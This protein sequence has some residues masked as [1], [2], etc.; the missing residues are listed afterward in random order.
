MSHALVL[1]GGGPVGVA[2]EIGVL[3]GLSEAGFDLSAADRVIGTSAGAIVG[4]Q[5]AT[6][7][8]ASDLYADHLDLVHR[9]TVEAEAG[10]VPTADLGALM[11]L[12]M[13]RPPGQM[14]SPALLS[15]MG[16]FALETG[17][18]GEEDFV[19][20]VSR[21][22]LTG[23]PWPSR[24]ACTAIEAATGTFKLWNAASGADL[25]RAVASSCAVP[26]LY[27]PITIDGRRYMDGGMRSATNAD[28]AAGADAVLVLAVTVRPAEFYMAAGARQE[29]ATLREQGSR[30]E[31]ILPDE[32]AL[33]AFGPN[34]MDWSRH[35]AVSAA[36]LAQ[37]RREAERLAFWPLS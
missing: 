37:G 25:D 23:Q 13:R 27:P 28:V 22:I 3:A 34:L 14:S 16:R 5:I 36:G 24:F 17:T 30:S 19:A 9:G 7:R 18:I 8:S 26:G 33:D 20:G 32:A 2:W 10:R 31:L 21:L 4:A 6:G 11:A 12:F 1:G 35:A 15:E 29:V